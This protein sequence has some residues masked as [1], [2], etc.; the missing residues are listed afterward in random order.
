MTVTGVVRAMLQTH[1]HHS[2]NRLPPARVALRRLLQLNNGEMLAP[3]Q[4][5]DAEAEALAS[6]ASP[7]SQRNGAGARRHDSAWATA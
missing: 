3:D 4:V 1:F 6:S 7:G 2:E 5:G